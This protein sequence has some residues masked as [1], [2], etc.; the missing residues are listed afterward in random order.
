MPG[1]GTSHRPSDLE[2]DKERLRGEQGECPAKPPQFKPR[3]RM[4]N[5]IACLRLGSDIIASHGW[6]TERGF[7]FNC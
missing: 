6:L 5:L 7:A 4:G 3:F 1:P 2:A